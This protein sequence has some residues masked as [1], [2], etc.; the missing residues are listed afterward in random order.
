MIQKQLAEGFEALGI[1]SGDTLLVHSSLKSLEGASPADVIEALLALLGPE[2]TLM[3]PTLSYLY[4]NRDNPVFDVRRTPSNVG[5]IPEYF[6]T[7]YPVL[8]S[9]CPTHSCAAVGLRAEYL[10]GSHH[11]DETPC[12]PNSPF[13]RLR[14]A[15]GKVLF[16]GCGT[17]PNT[18]MHAVEE[19]QRECERRGV[20]IHRYGDHLRMETRSEYAPYVERLLQPVQRQSLTQTAMETLAVIAYFQPVTR[21]YVDEVRGVD[22]SYTV[23]SLVEKG[24][25]EAAGRLEAPGR[26]TLYRTTEAFLRVMGVSELEELPPLPDMSSTDGLEKLQGAINALRGR[27]EQM[28]MDLENQETGGDAL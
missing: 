5:A 27:G 7:E 20:T 14:D 12:G 13:S 9:L 23:S 28:E 25:I 4:A 26:P 17:R 11:L 2:G 19:L 15:G 18:S 6:R 3:L 8:R 22:S 10:T 24:L 1:R 16:I 21:A